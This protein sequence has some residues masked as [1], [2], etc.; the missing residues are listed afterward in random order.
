[1]LIS[2][3]SLALF[4]HIPYAHSEEIVH[5]TTREGNIIVV[6]DGDPTT[7]DFDTQDFERPCL[8]TGGHAC[9]S[10]MLFVQHIYTVDAIFLAYRKLLIVL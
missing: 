3:L 1:L 10:F 9:E 5:T 6:A 4:A 7:G 8:V 2:T